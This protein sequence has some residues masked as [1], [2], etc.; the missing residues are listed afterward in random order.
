MQQLQWFTIVSISC[1]SQAL[2]NFL[3]FLLLIYQQLIINYNVLKAHAIH[4]FVYT[5]LRI[6]HTWLVAFV[7]HI[8]NCNSFSG[9]LSRQDSECRIFNRSVSL[10]MILNSWLV[11]PWLQPSTTRVSC[12][13]LKHVLLMCFNW[14]ASDS[15]HTC[16]KRRI[17]ITTLYKCGLFCGKQYWP[18]PPDDWTVQWQL[19]HSSSKGHAQFLALYSQRPIAL[20]GN[21]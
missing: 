7:L 18:H 9:S 11:L 8:L 19:F 17:T 16:H 14:P 13:R 2:L 5:S 15:S 12:D 3:Y 4:Y 10:L 21:N 20:T 6:V 1:N